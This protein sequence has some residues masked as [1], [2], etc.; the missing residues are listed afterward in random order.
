MGDFGIILAL[1]ICIVSA[2]C[3][4]SPVFTVIPCLVSQVLACPEGFSGALDLSCHRGEVTVV[5]PKPSQGASQCHQSCSK[6]VTTVAGW[7]QLKY[8]FY[9]SPYLGK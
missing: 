8:F 6:G 7:W 5:R 3:H 2:Y 4:E 1:I 9:F